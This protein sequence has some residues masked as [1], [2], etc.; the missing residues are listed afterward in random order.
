MIISIHGAKLASVTSTPQEAVDAAARAGFKYIEIPVT[1]WKINPETLTTKDIE[2]IEDI[3]KTGGVDA[4]S[5]GMIWPRDYGMVT[6]DPAEWKR[7][8][9]YADKL[10]KFS[11]ALG[12]EALNF[13]GSARSI[14]TSMPYYE[15][16]K[17]WVKFWREASR[18]AE[19]AGVIVC[20][21]ALVRSHRSNVGNT[22]KQIMDLVEAVN[23]PSFQINAQIHQ[24]A[25]TDLDVAAAIR[26]SGDRIKLVHIADVVGFN[27]AV[28]LIS[29]V[30][31]GKGILDFASVLKALKDINYDGE[32]C[33]EPQA[34]TLEGKDFVSELRAGRELLR[35]TWMRV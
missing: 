9:N 29:F 34:Q 8:I 31:P 25:Y 22:S 17:T 2:D 27:T 21:E 7:N 15:G 20:I 14:P 6:V 11:A 26:A 28:D 4:R 33:I 18:Y 13:G 1:T 32:L 30:T 35:A 24:M 5:L 3:L 23:S 12:I 10:F 19:D 16:L